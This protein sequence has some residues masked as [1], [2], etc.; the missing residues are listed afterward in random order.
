[1]AQNRDAIVFT[2]LSLALCG[3]F[4]LESIALLVG[5]GDE[6]VMPLVARLLILCLVA[7]VYHTRRQSNAS[8]LVARSHKKKKPNKKHWSL[9]T[10]WY[11]WIIVSVALLSLVRQIWMMVVVGR[12]F[13]SLFVV[14]S[15]L[16]M[17]VDELHCLW[18]LWQREDQWT[19]SL[20]TVVATEEGGERRSLYYWCYQRS[21]HCSQNVSSFSSAAAGFG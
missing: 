14:T 9:L 13:Y 15:S 2:I 6:T 8:K 16:V 4:G 3:F 17:L 7:G 11:N 12:L 10:E 20:D 18:W 19:H 1:M 21:H 5:G